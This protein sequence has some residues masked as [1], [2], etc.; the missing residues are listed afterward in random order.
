MEERTGVG[1]AAIS[2]PPFA[3]QGAY[4]PKTPLSKAN[5]AHFKGLVGGATFPPHGFIRIPIVTK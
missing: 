5:K 1:L 2:Q 4:M 3:H